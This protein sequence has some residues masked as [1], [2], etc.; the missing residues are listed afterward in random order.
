MNFRYDLNGLRAIAVIAV[1]LFHF[2]AKW[3]PG[4]FAGVDVFFVISGFLMTG[5]IFAGLE[6]D[7]FNVFKFYVARA[8]RI[9]PALAV[10]CLSL[11]VFGW[12]YLTPLDYQLLGKHTASSVSFISNI[13]YWKE[14]GY[15]DA[16]SYEKWL[17]HTW[18]LSVEWQ[19][20][21]I[22]PLVLMVLKKQFSIISLK[23][24][25]VFG[26]LLGFI[27]S[28]YATIKWPTSAYYILPTRA[29]EMMVGGIAYI[30]PL[31]LQD[32]KKKWAETIGLIFIFIS[33]IFVSSDVAWPGYAALLPV[34][35]AYLVIIANRQTS[36]ITN[37]FVAQAL[38][39]WSYSLY[40]W[41][42]P[43]VVYGY[44]TIKNWSLI[45]IPLSIFLGF[46]SY[47]LIESNKFYIYKS[48]NDIYKV[49]SI[50]QSVCVLLIGILVFKS[51]G[52]SVDCRAGANTDVAKYMDVYQRDNYVDDNLKNEYRVQC[53]YFDDDKYIAK[54]NEI[55]AK[56]TN[57]RRGE[58]I[59][60]WG[61]SHAQ[62][63]SYGLRKVFPSVQFNQVAS[64]G[65]RP[66]IGEDTKTSGEFK[67][68][69]DRSNRKAI[70]TAIKLN[71]KVIILVQRDEHDQNDFLGILKKLRDNKV[72]SKVIILGPVPQ[73]NP[74]LPKVIASRHFSPNEKIFVDRDFHKSLWAIDA[75]MLH[76]YSGT[77]KSAD[78]EY[79]SILRQICKGEAC[80]AKVD[81][82]N[83]PIVWD[84][85]HLTFKGSEYVVKNILAPHLQM[86]LP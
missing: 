18:S 54:K 64:S 77:D 76:D 86:Y 23:R 26:T 50:W 8:N 60:L 34:L 85:G 70:E 5:I 27:F 17:H 69:C 29:W 9:I 59:F 1:V 11:L 53:D 36:K 46:L 41:H 7:E 28:V 51:H 13:I 66:Q 61:D 74:S 58:G 56:C 32:N 3:L 16:S 31:P 44:Y 57:G 30:Y 42:W 4:G 52:V 21:I 37:N 67:V 35:G 14:S 79:I 83:T 25:L 49:K 45:G 10:L 47:K 71:P 33:Y 43:V 55:D 84:Y 68:A 63:L 20:Y 6:K 78:L 80:L 40:L 73:W 65:C 24:I 75:R 22:Y 12:F 39:K 72:N 62:A 81:D 82:Q 19:F 15:F 2:N 48:W 38:G